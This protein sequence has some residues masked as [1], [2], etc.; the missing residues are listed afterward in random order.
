[1]CVCVRESKPSISR[2]K[3]ERNESESQML[4]SSKLFIWTFMITLCFSVQLFLFQLLRGLAYCHSRR[5]LHRDLKPQNL[6]IS[7][8]GDLKLADFGE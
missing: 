3:R 7:E 8:N 6:L 5:V 4:F 2:L 1:M